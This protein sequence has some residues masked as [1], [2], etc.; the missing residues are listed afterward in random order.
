MSAC[1]TARSISAPLTLLILAGVLALT[2]RALCHHAA[3]TGAGRGPGHPALTMVKTP[4]YANLDY[5]E[6]RHRPPAERRLRQGRRKRSHVFVIN[7]SQGVNSGIRRHAA[8][9]LERAQ[10]QP[11]PDP[12]EPAAPL[13]D[14]TRRASLRL[15]S[16]L[17]ARLDRRPAG[18]IRHPHRAAT[19]ATSPACS[20]RCWRRRARAD[21]SSSPTA[22]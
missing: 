16:A 9:A 14:Q 1:S 13:A 17:A 19:T 5:L 21:C 18:A 7:G 12:A 20:T 10:A 2:G 3:R 15:R 22:T 4:Q 6:A 8:Q 11:E